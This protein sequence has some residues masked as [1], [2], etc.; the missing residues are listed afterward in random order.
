M[1]TL[2]KVTRPGAVSISPLA[3]LDSGRLFQFA[4]FLLT[5]INLIKRI[6]IHAIT[7]YIHS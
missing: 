2:D 1:M 7:K 5:I 3:L 6:Y 4:T